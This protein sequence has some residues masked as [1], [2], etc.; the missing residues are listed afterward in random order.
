MIPFCGLRN[1]SR[2]SI[3]PDGYVSSASSKIYPIIAAQI[4]MRLFLETRK[5]WRIGWPQL[6]FP[7]WPTLY[8][9]STSGFRLVLMS[10]KYWKQKPP[11][12]RTTAGIDKTAA[13]SEPVSLKINA[14]SCKKS[15]KKR[16]KC[17]ELYTAWY[18]NAA[19]L[20]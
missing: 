11:P 9:K 3:A 19:A 14:Y 12:T 10:T 1:V 4:A 16:E 7:C 8:T 13:Y 15:E 6:L 20:D 2:R 17:L 18:W 5:Q